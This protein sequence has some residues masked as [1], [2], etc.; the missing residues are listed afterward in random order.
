MLVSCPTS[1]KRRILGGLVSTPSESVRI[2]VTREM[3]E[4]VNYPL[5]LLS[6]ETYSYTLL[7]PTFLAVGEFVVGEVRSEE[8]PL[9]ELA[10]SWFVDMSGTGRYLW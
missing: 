3:D 2:S 1:I 4:L 10:E 9:S 6:S 7:L 8:V 5:Q